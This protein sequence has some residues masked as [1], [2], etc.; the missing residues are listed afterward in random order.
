MKTRKHEV[1]QRTCRSCRQSYA[2][3]EVGSLAT[4]FHCEACVELPAP[5]RAVFER[6][7]RHIVVLT[8]RIE[9]LEKRMGAR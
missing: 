2:Y 7:H 6:Y 3:P 4:R 8:G 9:S 1:E 5:V